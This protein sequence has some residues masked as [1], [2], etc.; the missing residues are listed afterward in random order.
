MNCIWLPT[1]PHSRLHHSQHCQHQLCCQFIVN[2][3]ANVNFVANINVTV[4]FI[5]FAINFTVNFA[6]NFTINTVMSSLLI[7]DVNVVTIY[8]AS[9][10]ST[11]YSRLA[12]TCSMTCP[13]VPSALCTCVDASLSC[14]YRPPEVDLYS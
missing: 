12:T 1:T 6:V 2:C 9:I 11:A 10:A 7:V 4:N 5:N 8:I 3:A 14:I 13:P